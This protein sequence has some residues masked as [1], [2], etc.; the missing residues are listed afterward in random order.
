MLEAHVDAFKLTTFRRPMPFVA[1]GIG[2]W[3]SFVGVMSTASV[4]TNVGLICFT[5]KL[6]NGYSPE[7]RLWI[8]LGECIIVYCKYGVMFVV[9]H[10]SG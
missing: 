10:N 8:F 3:L 1:E 7:N 9:L 6:L 4:V 2:A 5:S